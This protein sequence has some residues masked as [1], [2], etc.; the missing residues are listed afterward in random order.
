MY[1]SDFKTLMCESS[2]AAG[3]GVRRKTL[4]IER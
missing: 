4:Q 1:F 3:N 2:Q